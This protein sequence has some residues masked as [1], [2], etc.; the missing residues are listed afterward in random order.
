VT[1]TG[2]PGTVVSTSASLFLS[3]FARSG[4]SV[5]IFP[6]FRASPAPMSIVTPRNDMVEPEALE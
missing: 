6:A 4:S 1:S 3:A 5:Q 2:L